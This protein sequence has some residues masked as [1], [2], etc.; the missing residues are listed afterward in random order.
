MLV[1][2]SVDLLTNRLSEMTMASTA[3]QQAGDASAAAAAV[4][5]DDVEVETAKTAVALASLAARFQKGTPK[6][7][8]A[9]NIVKPGRRLLKEG[10]VC[11]KGVR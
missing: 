6:K 9:V 4:G 10:V 11:K 1:E 8:T 5:V 3:Q 7:E 2:V